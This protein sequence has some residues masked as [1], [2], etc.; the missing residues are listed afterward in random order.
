LR[1]DLHHAGVKQFDQQPIFQCLTTA[2]GI[3]VE[4]TTIKK[5]GS[6]THKG[7]LVI[8]AKPRWLKNASIPI[9]ET[10]MGVHEKKYLVLFLWEPLIIPNSSLPRRRESSY[11]ESLWIPAFAGM[12]FLELALCFS[13]IFSHYSPKNFL[14]LRR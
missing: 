9:G 4:R 7:S 13:Q 6:Q 14:N 3:I 8:T 12:T 5:G 11:L 2:A 10:M 1:R